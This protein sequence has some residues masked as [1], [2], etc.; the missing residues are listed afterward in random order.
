VDHAALIK[1]RLSGMSLTIVAKKHGLSRASVVRFVREA[2]AKQE[3]T[4]ETKPPA[5]QLSAS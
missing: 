1:D 3:Y 4:N 5:T 2:K